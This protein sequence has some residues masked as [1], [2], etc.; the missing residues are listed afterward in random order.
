MRVNANVRP[1]EAIRDMFEG[2]G[3]NSVYRIPCEAAVRAASAY[4]TLMAVG[5]DKFDQ[6]MRGRSPMESGGSVIIKE[7]SGF[8]H[9]DV[10]VPGD[11]ARVVN[12]AWRGD[13]R[14]D[15][16]RKASQPFNDS[17]NILYIGGGKF[18][19]P[20]FQDR[21]TSERTLPGWENLWPTATKLE[22]WRK[23]PSAGVKSA[24]REGG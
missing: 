16:N 8:R 10:W 17:E 21:E 9:E 14:D 5:A 12:T 18:F 4:G 20:G 2:E 3:K 13:K 22:N 19:G 24:S 11:W 23:F 1:S 7:M 15:P 6:M